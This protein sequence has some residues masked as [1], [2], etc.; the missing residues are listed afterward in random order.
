MSRSERRWQEFSARR[1]ERYSRLGR[2][3]EFWVEKILVD[4]VE[5]GELL[6]AVRHSPNSAADFAGKDFTVKKKVGGQVV[7]RSFG[8]TISHNS[9][10]RAKINHRD[11]PQFCFPIGTKPETVI[12]RVLDLFEDGADKDN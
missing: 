11:V 2:E 1:S 8:I 3:Q 10:N 4:A 9:W 6:G 12:M 7:I 5:C